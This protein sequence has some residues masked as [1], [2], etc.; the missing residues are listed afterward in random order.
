MLQQ[1]RVDTVIP[2]YERFLDR[3]PDVQTLAVAPEQSVLKSWEGLG[4]YSRARN[5]LA[6]A[7]EVAETYNGQLPRTS[8]ELQVLKGFGPYTSA[9]VASIAFGEPVACVDGNVKRV[10][11]R[12]F[13]TH[14]SLETRAQELLE[15]KDPSSF[16]QAMMELGALIC[17]PKNPR[18][19]I[20][21]MQTECA[22]RISNQVSK[23]PAKKTRT[24]PKEIFSVAVVTTSK[25]KILVRKRKSK[26]RFGGLWEFPTFEYLKSESPLQVAKRSMK[27]EFSTS[28]K[29]AKL[30]SHFDH[31]LTHRTIHMSAVAAQVE[32]SSS[33]DHH[34]W[35]AAEDLEALPFS[36]LQQKVANSV[37]GRVRT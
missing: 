24:A 2:Y 17:T 1:T 35:L 33:N 22:S 19:L 3:F 12:L 14:E 9:A 15:P 37:L 18:C 13:A 23:F 28:L 31:F 27:T 8:A 20:C 30:I 25:G 34:S 5:L 21:P 4:Y 32:R 11:S 6:A 36:K 10:V 16:N 7:K 26:G 29:T